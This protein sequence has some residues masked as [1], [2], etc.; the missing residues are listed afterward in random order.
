ML[1][2]LKPQAEKIFA[3]EQ[4]GFRAGRST[5][6]QIFNL[7]ILVRSIFSISR[8]STMSGSFICHCGNTG[9]ERTP[10]KSQHK[11]LTLEKKIFPPLLPGFELAT[12]R[13]RVRR[14]S[15]Q[16]MSASFVGLQHVLAP[17]YVA[18]KKER[19]KE[20]EKGLP[21]NPRKYSRWE[22]TER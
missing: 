14:S 15:Q 21:L 10:N 12:F 9:V 6:E 18:S 22:M 4:A 11:K 3:E 8:S 16:A 1:N 17:L 5:T 13:S 20:K 7:R 2:R 19:K